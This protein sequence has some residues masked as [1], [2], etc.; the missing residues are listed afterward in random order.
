MEID[1]PESMT[2]KTLEE[3]KLRK[4]YGINVLIIKR[5]EDDQAEEDS[6]ISYRTLGVPDAKTRLEKGDKFIIL[7]NKEDTQKMVDI[8]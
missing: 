4:R 8:N 1:V 2:D 7:G 5:P 3:L 6:D